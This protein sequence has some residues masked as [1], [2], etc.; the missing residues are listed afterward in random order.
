M[1]FEFIED[2]ESLEKLEKSWDLLC[3]AV[4][5]TATIFSSFTWYK[6]WWLFY[7]ERARL[8]L[9]TMWD[10]DKLVGIAPLMRNKSSLHKLPVK[11]LC[12]IQNNQSLHNDFIVLQEFREVF[13]KSMLHS[14]FERSQLWDVAYFRNIPVESKN[15]QTFAALLDIEQKRWEQK[16]T[17]FDSP[18]LVTQGENWNQYFATR[19]RLTRKNL[20]HITN[21]IHK[22]G[23]ASVKNITTLEEFLAC[24]EELFE[25]A[26]NSWAEKAGD[27]IGSLRNR[28]FFTSLAADAAEKGCLS[29]W[30]LYL[31]EKMIALEFHLKAYG[32]EHA[33]RGHYHSDF[34]ELSP[35]TY[36]EMMILKHRFN[37]NSGAGIYDFC[38]AFDSYKKKWTVTYAPHDDLFIFK[39]NIYSSCV[40][41]HEFSVVPLLRGVVQKFTLFGQG[42][43]SP[44]RESTREKA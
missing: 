33:L 5:A 6:N 15:Y 10:G 14:I 25:V 40:R 16:S 41:F 3:E 2:T 8:F 17:P 11:M 36:L 34:A 29:I 37:E 26:Q 42:R 4:N 13:I 7:G 21:K 22:A 12:F 24:K 30:T 39:D 43:R 1:R 19:S 44:I 9:F 27:S 18:F 32:R 28:E 38:G 35:G 23:C 31:D 20:N